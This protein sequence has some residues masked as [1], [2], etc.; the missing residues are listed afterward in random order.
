[1][2]YSQ[3]N[4]AL[5]DGCRIHAFRSGGGLR[6]VRIEDSKG[7]LQ[8]YGEHPYVSIALKHVDENYR[9]KLSYS[10]QYSS[11][12]SKYSHYLTGAYPTGTDM[13]DSWVYQ[14]HTFDA[15]LKDKKI[16][17]E[18]DGCK[19]DNIPSE[20]QNAVLET[21][22]PMTWTDKRGITRLTKIYTFANGSEGTSS[23]VIDNP[24]NKKT[25]FY[26]IKKTG[27]G[28]TFEEAVKKAVIAE[29]IEIDEKED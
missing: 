22:K 28:N 24:Q 9:T 10:K 15:Y 20:I 14:G 26:T 3:I 8:G 13:L 11:R 6:V 17:V 29:E 21:K 25:V 23:K 27:I 18:L 7:K 16:V 1:M 2:K 5:K 4:K 12:T 19:N